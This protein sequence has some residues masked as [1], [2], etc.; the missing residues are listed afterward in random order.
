MTA[1]AAPSPQ[2]EITFRHLTA[3]SNFIMP[4]GKHL[5]FSGPAGGVGE[6][7]TNDPNEIKELTYLAKQSNVPVEFVIDKAPETSTVLRKPADPAI[8][9]A[10]VEAS[11]SSE[12]DVNPVI[13]AARD[14]LAQTIAGDKNAA[15]P[16]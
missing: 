15:V 2:K 4:S 10:V 16:S 11:A 13:A 6:Y 5:I 8:A 14:R 3:G 9:A 12:K 7:T 1:T